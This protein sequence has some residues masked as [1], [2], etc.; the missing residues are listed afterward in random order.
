MLYLQTFCVFVILLFFDGGYAASLNPGSHLSVCYFT[1]WSQYRTDRGKF[2]PEDVDPTLCTHIIYAFANIDGNN[3]KAGE[4][5]DEST[6]SGKGM[7]ARVL[8]LKQTN[9]SL[10]VLL[11]VGGWVMGTQPLLLCSWKRHK[12]DTVLLNVVTYLTQQG[13]DGL[14]M[15]WE[16]PGS[17]GSPPQDKH[18]FVLLMQELHNAFINH[19]PSPLLLSTAVGVGKWTIDAGYDVPALSGIVDFFNL[20]TYDLHGNWENSTGHNAPLFVHPSDTGDA[21]HLN[22]EWAVN[23][24][25]SLGMPPAKMVLGIPAYGRS[26]TLDD[27][28]NNGIGAPTHKPGAPGPYTKEAGFI[29]YYEICDMLKTGVVH[30][31]IPAQH[32][33]YV[34]SG[35]QW[36]GYDDQQSLREKA[37]FARSLGLAGVMFWALDLDDFSGQ[38]CGQGKYPLI[39]AATREF[40][41]SDLSACP[42]PPQITVAPVAMTTQSPFSAFFMQKFQDCSD[43]WSTCADESPDSC[44]TD[45]TMAFNCPSVCGC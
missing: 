41:S 31:A 9:P 10:K 33:A 25:I 7:Y 3:L 26:F 42:N 38:S 2:V 40:Q 6:A 21:S 39:T 23:Y 36:V 44:L 29:S 19:Q 30:Y 24:L 5:S 8:A 12:Q 13:F 1:S 18:N 4:P 16:Y 22:V 32:A 35:S 17:R 45:T 34:T 27:P 14:D 43:L 20:M 15:D 28:S 11:G 37:C